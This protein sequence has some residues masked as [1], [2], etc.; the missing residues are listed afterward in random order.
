[1][2]PPTCCPRKLTSFLIS[3]ENSPTKTSVLSRGGPVN[4]S[5]LVRVRVDVGV[6]GC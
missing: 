3:R 4:A 1:M 2:I 5:T 6:H